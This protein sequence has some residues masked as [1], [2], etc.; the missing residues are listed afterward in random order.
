M[1]NLP[2]EQV[3]S[4]PFP[5]HWHDGA[6]MASCHCCARLS[7]DD[8]WHSSRGTATSLMTMFPQTWSAIPTAGDHRLL[9]IGQGALRA[10]KKM[11]G[12][13]RCFGHPEWGE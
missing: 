9:E 13:R 8:H 1:G 12:G 6:E 3:L 10:G 11:K 2:G 4:C 5:G 7:W